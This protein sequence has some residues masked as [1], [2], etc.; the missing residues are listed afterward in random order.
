MISD[1]GALKWW[2]V[3]VL[4]TKRGSVVVVVVVVVGGGGGDVWLVWMVCLC[5]I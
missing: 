5:V 3:S 2:C 4:E 1:M